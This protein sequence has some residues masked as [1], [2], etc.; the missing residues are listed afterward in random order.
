MNFY[1]DASHPMLRYV[2]GIELFF[3]V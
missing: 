3:V 2:I 1:V